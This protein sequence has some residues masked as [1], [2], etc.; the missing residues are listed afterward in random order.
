VVQPEA[1]DPFP[2]SLYYKNPIVVLSRFFSS[3]TNVGGFDLHPKRISGQHQWYSIPSTS[4]WWKSMQEYIDCHGGVIA[5]LIFYNDVN[6]SLS[7]NGKVIGYLLVLSLHNIASKLKSQEKGHILLPMYLWYQ[8]QIFPPI[9]NGCKYFMSKFEEDIW[10]IE[11]LKFQ[12]SWIH[13]HFV[14]V[15]NLYDGILWNGMWLVI[16]KTWVCLCRG[17]T[18]TNSFGNE[19]FVSPLLYGFF[20]WSPIEL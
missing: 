3:P 7:N 4:N 5:P 17:T 12:A 11:I 19:Q 10:I 1:K 8:H 15:H 2:I 13:D 6:S 18:M 9:N 16:L 14:W 20:V